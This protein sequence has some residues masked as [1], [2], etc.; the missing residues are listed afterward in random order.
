MSFGC[1]I[2]CI[3]VTFFG[4]AFIP[5]LVSIYPIYDSSFVSLFR[6]NSRV[7]CST[8]RNL[9]LGSS[10]VL[11]HAKIS[12]TM[13]G[14]PS[15]SSSACDIRLWNTSGAELIPNGSLRYLYRPNGELKV[16]SF[17]LSR[18][19]LTCQNPDDASIVLKN[20]ASFNSAATCSMVFSWVVIS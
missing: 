9:V 16:T 7:L 6:F 3:A 2:S 14:T 12:S 18:S 10:I 15:I 20:V 13:T 11:P 8:F 19:I 17:E 4:S 5:S 1:W